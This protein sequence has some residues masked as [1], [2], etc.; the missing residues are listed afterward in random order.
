MGLRAAQAHP[1]ETSERAGR[2]GPRNDLRILTLATVF[3]NSRNSTFGV[4]VRSRM[5]HVAELA[6]VKVIA[7]VPAVDYSHPERDFF[8]SRAMER[9][10]QDGPIEV[11]QPRWLYP[12]CGTRLN[13]WCLYG[14][15][16]ALARRIRETWPF[17]LI[18]A[19]FGYPDGV[20][21]AHLA[22]ALRCP[23]LITL[24]GNET[25]FGE[26]PRIRESMA[27]A[28]GRAA[29]VFSVSEDL[30]RF[31]LSLGVEERRTRTISNGIDIDRFC[32]RDRLEGRARFG[33][34]PAER[35]IV[36]V[37]SLVERKGHHRVIRALRRVVDRGV[38]AR[39]VI[40]GGP[41]PEGRFEQQIRDTI[42]ETGMG[43]RVS[44]L[45][46][47]PPAEL[48]LLMSAADLFCLGS[49][50]EGWPNV[51]H[52]AQGC[53]C[54]VVAT[55]VGGVP[56]MIPSE[57]FG[58]VVPPGDTEAM[59]GALEQ[60]LTRDWDRDAISQWGRSRSWRQV[61]AEVADEA[62]QA[63]AEAGAPARR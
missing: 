19:H 21:A 35:M 4:F 55:S 27:W 36:S 6:Q 31:A 40:A 60:A 16:L 12:P 47:V 46:P 20:A 41:G 9:R 3:P 57:R 32:P 18:D 29:R 63:V 58:F 45:G 34:D 30:R 48:P 13:I 49:D 43:G 52:E 15:V 33:V 8:A 62:A 1:G 23:F 38:E 11:F 39:L 24:R 51:V 5:Q 53:G 37:G 14:R 54:P 44:M 7:P 28:F 50:M 42:A 25:R 61:A 17:D 22:A 56:D 26:N 2:S 10:R 59:A